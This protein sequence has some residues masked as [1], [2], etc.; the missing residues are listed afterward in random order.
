MSILLATVLVLLL[1]LVPPV[2]MVVPFTVTLDTD[3][4]P[5]PP[6]GIVAVGEPETRV[7]TAEDPIAEAGP[8]IVTVQPELLP[9]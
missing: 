5:D 3:V 2:V 4:L 7:I 1:A 8:L 9:A 6:T